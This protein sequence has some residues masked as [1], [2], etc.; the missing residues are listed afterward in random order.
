MQFWGIIQKD[1][2]QRMYLLRGGRIGYFVFLRVHFLY[3]YARVLILYTVEEFASNQTHSYWN[4]HKKIRMNESQISN[5]KSTRML[6]SKIAVPTALGSLDL[7]FF[8]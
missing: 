4:H 8:L 1:P 6:E 5:W 7:L 3:V 2:K